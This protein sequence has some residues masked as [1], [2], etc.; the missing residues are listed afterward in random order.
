MK[1]SVE[2]ITLHWFSL[3]K[4]SSLSDSPFSHKLQ[5][6]S[7]FVHLFKFHLPRSHQASVSCLVQSFTARPFYIFLDRPHVLANH[8]ASII[9]HISVYLFAQSQRNERFYNY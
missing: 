5:S 8:T 6:T 4:S 9:H 1:A 3:S 7:S 2:V